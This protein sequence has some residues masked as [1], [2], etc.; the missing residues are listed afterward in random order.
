M[1]GTEFLEQES[2][3]TNTLGHAMQALDITIVGVSLVV[4]VAVGLWASRRQEKTARGYFL[5]SGK[6]PW[7]IIGGAFVST[8]VSSEQIVGTDGAAYTNGMGVAN[9]EWFVLPVYTP[10]MVFFIPIYLKNRVT[11][12]PELLGRRYGPLCADAY[13]WIML[14]AYVFVFMVPVLYGGSLAFSELTG[15]SFHAVLW[16]IVALVGAYTIKGGLASVVWTDAIQCVMLIGGGLLLFFVALS[17]ID[18]G[19]S[20]MVEANPDRFHLYRPAGDETAPFL[21]LVFAT[22]G[23]FLFYSAGNQVMV[24]RILGARSTWDGLMGIVFASYINFI[25]PLVTC[26]LGFVVYHWIHV[27]HRAE[28]LE[29]ADM[30]FPFAL[31]QLAPDWGL[32]GIVLTGFLAAVMSTISALANSTATIFSLDVY[33]KIISPEADDRR[34]VLVGRLASFTAL[35]LAGIVAPAVRH[36]GGIFQY[37]Q[38]G[39]TY[40]ATPFITAMLVGILWRRATYAA[41]IFCVVGGLI[42]QLAVAIGLPLA[43]IHLHWLYCGFIAQVI[44]V[45]GMVVVSLMTAPPSEEQWKPY[46]WSPSLL[47]QYAEDDPKPWYARVWLWMGL[48]AVIWFYLYWQFW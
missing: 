12:V 29:H 4:V 30:A 3:I 1:S 22:F 36:F 41:G 43:G 2:A 10:L 17:Q 33:R 24:Q 38:T 45:I 44:I 13:S 19:W 16:L 42:I 25:R 26:F 5:A 39:V 9:W 21:G 20:A 48:Y 23:V 6:L 34:T 8:S 27:M 47:K 18:G 46:R 14:V 35:A 11:T 40:L 32:R 28:P 37:F 15:W 31:S 7:Y